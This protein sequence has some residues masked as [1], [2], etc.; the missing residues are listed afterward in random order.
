MVITK[1]F[2]AWK[3]VDGGTIGFVP[4]SQATASPACS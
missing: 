2:H 1:T 3:T 4:A